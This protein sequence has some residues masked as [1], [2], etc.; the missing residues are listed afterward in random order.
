MNGNSDDWSD[1][2][3]PN[4]KEMKII[5]RGWQDVPS[6]C[7]FTQSSVQSTSIII[8]MKL[9]SHWLSTTHT[10]TIFTWYLTHFQVYGSTCRLVLHIKW[11]S[12]GDFAWDNFFREFIE[13]KC[14][15]CLR[16]HLGNCL[17]DNGIVWGDIVKAE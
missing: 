10:H 14:K 11:N 6:Y 5:V 7:F 3:A 2:I 9:R 15:L 17:V 4:L 16:D 8:A 12:F 1:K 13:W